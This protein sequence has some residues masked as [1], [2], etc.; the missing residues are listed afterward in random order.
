MKSSLNFVFCVA[1]VGA[2]LPLST[3]CDGGGDKKTIIVTNQ[4]ENASS[5]GQIHPNTVEDRDHHI[6]E[7]HVNAPR[8][9]ATVTIIPDN[10]YAYESGSRESRAGYTHSETIWYD[11][12]SGFEVRRYRADGSYD[13]EVVNLN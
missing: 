5:G 2:L 9:E 11:D 4:V 6:E 13:R 7:E 3:G 1:L 10:A 12:G 8:G